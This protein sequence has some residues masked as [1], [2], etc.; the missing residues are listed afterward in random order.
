M[1]EYP[2]VELVAGGDDQVLEFTHDGKAFVAP[3]TLARGNWNIRM[4][5]TAEDGTL[6]SR[7]LVLH[8]K[9]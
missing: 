5:A 1:R 7:R 2:S 9:K 4:T 3:V 8:V 6:Y